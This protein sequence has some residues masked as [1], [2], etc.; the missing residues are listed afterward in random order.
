MNSGKLD[1]CQLEDCFFPSTTCGAGH[2]EVVQ[3]PHYQ[4]DT[5]QGETD[6]A[7]DEERFPWT[8]RPFGLKDLRFVS[9]VRRP[10]VVG[11]LGLANA[12]KTTLLGMLFLM[13]YRGHQ[14]MDDAAFAGSFTLQGWEN[15]ARFLQLNSDGPIQFPPHTTQSG[16]L[17]GL[18]HLRF[19]VDGERDQDFLL[20]DAPG[21]WFSHWT[22]NAEADNAAGARWIAA[23]ANKVMIVAD[24]EALTGPQKG[25]ARTN[26]EFL[27]RRV[28][29]NFR[30]DAV[31]LLWSKTDLPRPSELVATVN[32]HFD[33]CFPQSPVFSVQ[34]PD[35]NE[36]VDETHLGALRELFSVG[37]HYRA[38]K[39]KVGFAGIQDCGPVL[40]VSRL[41]MMDAP[42]S[43]LLL[44]E[45]DVGKTHYGAQV[46]RRLNAGRGAFELVEG[47]NLTPFKT[48]LKKISQGLSAPHTPRAEYTE[49]TWTLR[50]RKSGSNM[51]IVWPDY[52]G[53]QVSGMV[54]GR[55]LP[56]AWRDKIVKASGWI[57]LVRPS[58]VS[59]PEDI[60]TR[61]VSFPAID[62]PQNST[63]SPQSKLIE[64]LQ[65]LQYRKQSYLQHKGTLPP[66]AV[67]LTCYDELATEESPDAYCRAHLPMFDQYLSSN[68][69]KERLRIFGVSP[70]GQPLNPTQPDEDYAASG[71]ENRG[72]IVNEQGGNTDDLLAP[73]EWLLSISDAP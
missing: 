34:V 8:G 47:T 55:S 23:N 39:N 32:R 2:M 29:S 57:F 21:E 24:T 19:S 10:H 52:G 15:I 63:L 36:A 28:Q 44:G 7:A 14:I 20:T 22:D 71:P 30:K 3:C 35:K 45:S 33:N 66:L 51:D 62:D 56:A 42:R 1:E 43:L 17:P 53:E 25:P 70:L 4:Q 12:G 27:I 73:L 48:A 64:V 46:L 13:I 69:P 5:G 38:R 65:M 49:S 41:A 61:A 68:W 16:R 37:V 9:S 6:L 59:L 40:I 54:D 72:F 31:A 26:L 58:Q 50:Q 18:L 67:L 11:V 60:L